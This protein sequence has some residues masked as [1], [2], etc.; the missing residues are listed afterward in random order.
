MISQIKNQQLVSHGTRRVPWLTLTLTTVMIGL[1]LLGPVPFDW[2]HFDKTAIRHGEIWRF[3]TGHFVHCNFEHLFWDILAFLVLGSIIEFHNAKQFLLSFLSS[4]IL[5]S[6]WLFWGETKL[7]TYCGLSGALNG[8]L[9]LAVMLQWRIK[10]EG[11]YLYVLF[12]TIGKIIFELITH[13]TLFTDLSSQA[14]PSSHAAGF[15]AGMIYF[16]ISRKLSQH[17]ILGLTRL[18]H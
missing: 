4:C 18:C 10:R 15:I 7:M 17:S 16:T 13:Q 5:V 2:L 12:A 6:M 14:V 9:V 3:L 8:L 1:Y 11:I